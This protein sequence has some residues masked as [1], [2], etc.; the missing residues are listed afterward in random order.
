MKSILNFLHSVVVKG[1]TPIQISVR[2]GSVTFALVVHKLDLR[3]PTFGVTVASYFR[4]PFFA[5]AE[6]YVGVVGVTF[7]VYREPAE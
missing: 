5:V 6:L 7:D 2:I 1:R 4:T 3:T